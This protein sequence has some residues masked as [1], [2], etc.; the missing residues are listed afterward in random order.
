MSKVTQGRRSKFKIQ[1]RLGLELPG[2]GKA[3]ALAR[4]PYGPGQ[5][6]AQRKKL[7]DFSVRLQEKQKIIFHYGLREAQLIR[8]IKKSRTLSATNKL[9]WAD[10]LVTRLERRLDNVVFRLNWAPSMAAARQMVAH[11]QVMVN[12]KKVNVANYM[13]D[14]GDEISLTAKGYQ[15][16]NFK[17]AATNPR[18]S[19]VPA[20]FSVT[21]ADDK[22][23][24]KI[25]AEPLA[26]D[27]PFEFEPK[28]FIEYYW[29]LK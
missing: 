21:G 1:R 17:R 24:A 15:T 28:L 16:D 29:K 5:H 4:R 3:G 19:S 25:V 2:L 18:I 6:G 8:Y 11:K 20:C 23:K 27:I 22:K 26:T 13:V 10:I 9:S 14:V 12:G 7:S